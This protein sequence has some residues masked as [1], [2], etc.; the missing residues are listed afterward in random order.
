MDIKPFL[1]KH[2]LLYDCYGHYDNIEEA[3]CDKCNQQIDG[4]AYSCESCRKFWLHSYC[5]EEQLPPQIS[6]P[7]HTQHLLTLFKGYDVDD[8]ICDKCFTLSR[9]HRY[10]CSGC[11]F[12]VD[13]SCAASTNDAALLKL[14]SKR[15][16]EGLRKIQHFVHTNRL[17]G[18]FNYR[19]VAKKH[20]NCGWC[21]KHLSGMTYG[22]FES[23]EKFYIHESCLIKIPTKLLGHPF[24]SSHPLY[25]QPTTMVNNSEPRCNACKDAILGKAY[26]CQKCEFHL[27]VLCLR[28]QPCL[29]HEIHEH[30]L[31]SFQKNLSEV[32]YQCNICYWNIGAEY[33]EYWVDSEALIPKLMKQEETEKGNAESQSQDL[34]REIEHFTHRHSLSYYEV[35]EKNEDVFCKACDFEIHGQAY[36]CESCEYYLHIRCAKLSYEVL[37]PLHPKHPLRLSN[38]SQPVFCNECGDFSFGFSYVCY[39]CDF[40]LDVKCVTSTEPNN[41]GQRLK[42]MARESKLCPLEQDHELSFFNFRHK[43]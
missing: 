2:Y 33:W 25:L 31:T 32:T 21:E 9:G 19:K 42:E 39:F 4:W 38:D 24:H 26:R 5:A 10:H 40:K 28:L 7:L 14:E 37:H 3:S 27:H 11:N 36:G 41:E 30:S 34:E 17:T 16:D 35:I 23:Y 20:Y 29:K 8:F 15:S 22:C 13:V 43:V 18:I 1:H 12:K 6:H